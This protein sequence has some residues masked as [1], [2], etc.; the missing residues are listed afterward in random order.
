MPPSPNTPG[1]MLDSLNAPFGLIL[2]FHTGDRI[3]TQP[4]R[5]S[6]CL[7]NLLRESFIFLASVFTQSCQEARSKLA[8]KRQ[9]PCPVHLGSDEVEL[10]VSSEWQPGS[11]PFTH[12]HI[13]R[14]TFNPLLTIACELVAPYKNPG[15]SAAPTGW[16]FANIFLS[17]VSN[18]P[19]MAAKGRL[20]SASFHAQWRRVEN[21]GSV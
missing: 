11:N 9:L 19:Q 3:P 14:Q 7:R 17:V 2:Q 16:W 13:K 8:A 18:T 6:D 12:T 5:K 10:C 1:I 15:A 4:L 20:R 21:P